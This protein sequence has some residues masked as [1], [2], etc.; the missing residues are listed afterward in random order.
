[1][2]N[3]LQRNEKSGTIYLLYYVQN[4]YKKDE[5]EDMKRR[6]SKLLTLVLSTALL[7]GGC[8]G[9]SGK[10]TTPKS[11]VD[12]E[13]R[14]ITYVT[15][16]YE[17]DTE[18]K[19]VIVF[20]NGVA[21]LYD[22][23]DYTLGDFAQMTDDEVVENLLAIIE[24]KNKTEIEKNQEY[25]AEKQS[26]I[27]DLKTNSFSVQ[28]DKSCGEWL[29]FAI[30]YGGK[31]IDGFL[32]E[33]YG[34]EYTEYLETNADALYIWLDSF[35]LYLTEHLTGGN[36][37]V[38]EALYNL[39]Q[40]NEDELFGQGTSLAEDWQ[41]YMARHEGEKFAPIF[42]RYVNTSKVGLE[43]IKTA[44]ELFD[45]VI[46]EGTMVANEAVN[47][48]NQ[49]MIDSLQQELD[50]YNQKIEELQNKEIAGE[51]Y[52]TV[53]NLMT[54]GTGNNVQ[55]EAF[56][57]LG[58]D[59]IEYAIGLIDIVYSGESRKAIYDSQYAVYGATTDGSNVA[60]FLL[61]RDESKNGAKFGIDTLETKGI[62]IDAEEYSDFTE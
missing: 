7:L 15:E 35:S 6:I 38:C 44:T 16:N 34:T 54:D 30:G 51:S 19:K 39:A 23:G 2:Q 9:A 29:K 62:Y 46:T 22:T 45:T 31:D 49:E 37:S 26:K 53:V 47:S 32:Y 60:G 1:M 59:S 36:L 52:P 57:M 55:F 58:E 17:K 61:I 28:N 41:N 5:E 24:E 10:A 43:E 13:E 11:I 14:T 25:L 33:E 3:V 4:Y 27:K 50:T 42:E 56:V 21:T 20:E 40:Q 48:N 12:S 18:P 8:G